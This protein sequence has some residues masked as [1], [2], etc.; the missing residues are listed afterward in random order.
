M[1]SI[2]WVYDRW[3][4]MVDANLLVGVLEIAELVIGIGFR[5]NYE[6]L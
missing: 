5:R 6:V 4:E 3:V 1:G 2:G